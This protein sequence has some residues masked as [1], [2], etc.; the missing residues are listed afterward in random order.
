MTAAQETPEVDVAHLGDSTGPWVA[1]RWVAWWL[2]A[3]L[4]EAPHRVVVLPEAPTTILYH[5]LPAQLRRR[6][7]IVNA[8]SHLCH[9]LQDEVRIERRVATDRGRVVEDVRC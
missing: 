1:E 2:V 7:G 6:I 3:V 9:A 5:V 8:T 4:H